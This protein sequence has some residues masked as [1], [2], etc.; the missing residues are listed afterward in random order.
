MTADQDNT[1]TV[2]QLLA[3]LRDDEARELRDFRRLVEESD[4]RVREASRY[5]NERLRNIRREI[6][7]LT[8]AI[9]DFESLKIPPPFIEIEAGASDTMARNAEPPK[10]GPKSA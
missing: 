5:L 1:A 8:K 6:E 9:A 3:K 4:L 2:R 10:S 7:A